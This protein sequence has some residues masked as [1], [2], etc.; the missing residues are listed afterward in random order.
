[1]CGLL[2]LCD[3][4]EILG[5]G[6]DEITMPQ[7]VRSTRSLRNGYLQYQ[8]CLKPRMEEAVSRHARLCR[9]C[10]A[11]WVYENGADALTCASKSTSIVP[12]RMGS[13]RRTRSIWK[14]W[15]FCWVGRVTGECSAGA[16]CAHDPCRGWTQGWT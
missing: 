14:S 6:D 12:R 10:P 16:S 2:P 15:L 4:A 5:S 3:G 11:G 9:A 7:V 1:M 13:M 8:H